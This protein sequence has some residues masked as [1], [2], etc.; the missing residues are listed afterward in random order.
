MS[1]SCGSR[2]PGDT[3]SPRKIDVLSRGRSLLARLNNHRKAEGAAEVMRKAAGE[4]QHG[5]I[6]RSHTV[7]AKQGKEF[8]RS[9]AR[10][11]RQRLL[12]VS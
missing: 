4:R 8:G 2:P 9:F 11:C 12:L 7:F 5:F 6:R 3:L 10:R 1:A